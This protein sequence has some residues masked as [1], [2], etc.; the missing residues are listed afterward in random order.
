MITLILFLYLAMSVGGL[1]LFIYGVFCDPIGFEDE[2]GYVRIREARNW[3]Q[4]V[5]SA[6]PQNREEAIFERY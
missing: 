6:G 4:S 2:S 1:C 3:D 5:A